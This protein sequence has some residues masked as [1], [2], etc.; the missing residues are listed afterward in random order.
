M[1]TSNLEYSTPH[2]MAQ[3]QQQQQAHRVNGNSVALRQSLVDLNWAV[4]HSHR[5][6][7]FETIYRTPARALM[8]PLVVNKVYCTWSV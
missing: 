2:G 7:M 8:L 1:A 6:A 3:Q 4:S 5:G